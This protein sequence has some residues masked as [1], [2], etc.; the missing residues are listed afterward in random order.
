MCS[1]WKGSFNSSLSLSGMNTASGLFLFPT[2]Q[3]QWCNLVADTRNVSFTLFSSL[4]SSS[5]SSAVA[6]LEVSTRCLLIGIDASKSWQGSLVFDSRIAFVLN[7]AG[8]Q[9][10]FLA[11]LS[12]WI[13]LSSVMLEHFKSFSSCGK[14]KDNAFGGGFRF[15]QDRG[16]LPA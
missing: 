16:G 4:S 12:V 2:A 9:F 13:C 6:C 3:S 7:G 1:H 11:C 5:S 14:D 8:V 15:N 10:T